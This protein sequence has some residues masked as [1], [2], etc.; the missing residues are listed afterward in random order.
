MS[1]TTN[2]KKRSFN[3]IG[4]FERHYDGRDD[5]AVTTRNLATLLNNYLEEY[6]ACHFKKVKLKPNIYPQLI[7]TYFDEVIKKAIETG[8]SV[9]LDKAG[10]I[11]VLEKFSKKDY[12]WDVKY[13]GRDWEIILSTI[14]LAR[15]K[16]SQKYMKK[17]LPLAEKGKKYLEEIDTLGERIDEILNLLNG[18]GVAKFDGRRTKRFR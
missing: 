1:S 6:N 4:S 2:T 17:L 9:P 5:F 15:T 16:F 8:E 18:K 14:P 3:K 13:G 12:K 7:Q 11:Q 10:H